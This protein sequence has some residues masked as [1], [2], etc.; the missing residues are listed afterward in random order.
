MSSTCEGLREYGS[1]L[2][3]CYTTLAQTIRFVCIS[4]LYPTGR[5]R[6][7][8]SRTRQS[9]RVRK[10]RF[11]ND[12]APE[13]QTVRILLLCSSGLVFLVSSVGSGIVHQPLHFYV[14]PNSDFGVEVWSMP[15]IACVRR[16]RGNS[17]CPVAWLWFSTWMPC[18]Y[19]PGVYSDSDT[20]YLPAC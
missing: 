15:T 3:S 4:I 17:V 2:D 8:Q 13:S 10:D 1:T 16:Y 6:S 20:Y 19:H 5:Y 9:S 11:L 18:R 12:G 14:P 7:G